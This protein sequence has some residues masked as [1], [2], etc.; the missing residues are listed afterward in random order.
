MDKAAVAVRNARASIHKKLQDMQKRKEA[1]PDDI[2]KAHDQMEKLV[3]KAQK[4]VKDDFES[5][6]KCM[7]QS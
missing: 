3:E 2:R 6:R 5:A 4:D 1:R 7:E